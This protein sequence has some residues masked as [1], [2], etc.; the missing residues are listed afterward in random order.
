[1]YTMSHGLMVNNIV[2]DSDHKEKW[3]DG[4]PVGC[5]YFPD[6]SGSTTDITL[7]TNLCLNNKFGGINSDGYEGGSNNYTTVNARNNVVWDAV[8][9]SGNLG[10][11]VSRGYNSTWRNN[12]FGVGPSGP[13]YYLSLYISK[14]VTIYNN[15]FYNITA[16][17]AHAWTN[18]T[19]D[20]NAFYATNYGMPT[21]SAHERTNINPIWNASTNPTGALKYITRIESGS[22]LVGIGQNGENIGATLQYM[23]GVPGTL[24]GEPGYNTVQST[25]MWP[26]PNENVIKSKMAAYTYPGLSGARGFAASGTGLY[27]GPITLTS[28]IWEYLGNPCPTDICSYGSLTTLLAPSGLTIVK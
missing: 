24:W 4:Y 28:Y 2:I 1:M 22:N 7:D 3:L 21:L 15:L 27:G 13:L 25:P 16:P 6:T 14:G 8:G 10:T 11:N 17:L 18:G 20:Y 12:T 9:E 19:H 26:F 5:Y 23:I